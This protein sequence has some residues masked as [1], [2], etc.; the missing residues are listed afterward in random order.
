MAERTR[1][2]LKPCP[3]CGRQP[4]VYRQ[5]RDYKRP[6]I[7]CGELAGHSVCVWGD[8]LTEA[9]RRWNERKGD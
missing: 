7:C 5:D 3:M 8:T 6:K 1:I 9:C 4:V 2:K